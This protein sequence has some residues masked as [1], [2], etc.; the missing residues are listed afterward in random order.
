MLSA[1]W[2]D[3]V[4]FCLALLSATELTSPHAQNPEFSAGQRLPA[5]IIM[6]R[7]ED[8]YAIDADKSMDAS[9][10]LNVLAD[11]VRCFALSAP[12][13]ALLANL[14]HSNDRET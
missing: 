6:H 13:I 8:H 12:L 11:Y 5:S 9:L 4:R 10:N 3:A 7:R 2:Q 14:L 1:S